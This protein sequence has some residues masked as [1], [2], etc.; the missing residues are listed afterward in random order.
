MTKTTVNDTNTPETKKRKRAKKSNFYFTKDTEYA[1]VEYNNTSCRR[2]RNQLFNEKIHYPFQKIAENVYNKYKFTY[3]DV[4]PHIVQE[5]AVSFMA[6]QLHKYKAP[7]DGGRKA[8]SYFTVV[9]KNWYILH[10]N[11][12]WKKWNQHTEIIDEPDEETNGQIL[13]QFDNEDEEIKE[14]VELMIHYWDEN[15]TN[16]FTKRKE[17]EIANAVLE[18]FKNREKIENFN[19]KTLYLYIREMSGCKTQNIT[20][21]INVMKLYQ[22]DILCQY[23]NTGNVNNNITVEDTEESFFSEY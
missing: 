16:V 12:T 14:F 10:N 7:D 6:S 17:L 21:V 5:Q 15:L 2:R 20:K 18:L 13:M 1:I 22:K 3:F 8:Y 11:T 4:E 23:L 9:A 19:K